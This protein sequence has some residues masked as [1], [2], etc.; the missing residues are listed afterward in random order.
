MLTFNFG[1]AFGYKIYN[2]TYNT[3]TNISNI[4]SGRN[5]SASSFD[6]KESLSGCC[7]F[8]PVP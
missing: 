8:Y 4:K 5:V 6:T 1:G 7:G 3:V 2:N